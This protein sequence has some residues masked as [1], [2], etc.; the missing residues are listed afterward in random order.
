MRRKTIEFK[1]NEE[2]ELP[3]EVIDSIP[4]SG[5]A[6]NAAAELRQD[7]NFDVSLDDSIKFL[8][9]YGAWNKEE[10][11]D[12]DSNIDRIIWLACLDCQENNTTFFYM[13]E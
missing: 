9:S 4:M 3:Q 11:Q 1:L 12:L 10:L 13:G 5:Q 2:T 8:S 6:D 7:Y